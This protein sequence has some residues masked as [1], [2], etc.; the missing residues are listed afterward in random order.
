MY[1]KQTC[2]AQVGTKKDVVML[3]DVIRRRINC[4]FYIE[5][6]LTIPAI[7]VHL[8]SRFRAIAAGRQYIT[9][10]AIEA[11]PNSVHSKPGFHIHIHIGFCCPRRNWWISNMR[12][13]KIGRTKSQYDFYFGITHLFKPFMATLAVKQSLNLYRGLPWWKWENLDHIT[14]FFASKR[15]LST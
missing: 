1:W 2:K 7:T 8:E 6:N 12:G 4:L 14:H 3:E 15:C 10:A 9:D 11:T 13:K 5:A